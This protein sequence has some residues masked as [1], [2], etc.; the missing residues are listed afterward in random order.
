MPRKG[1]DKT[2]RRQKKEATN[3]EIGVKILLGGFASLVLHIQSTNKI[4][5]YIYI[6]IY[7]D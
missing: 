2:S 7:I 6:Y 1:S 4:R 5:M 3:P